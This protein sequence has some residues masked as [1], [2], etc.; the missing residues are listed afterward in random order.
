MKLMEPITIYHGNPLSFMDQIYV[1]QT[2]PLMPTILLH[3]LVLL[4]QKNV[5]SI[6]LGIDSQQIQFLLLKKQVIKPVVLHC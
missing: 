2:R 3:A 1:L 4:P 6:L 5:L